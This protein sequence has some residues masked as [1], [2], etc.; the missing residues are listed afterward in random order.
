MVKAPEHFELNVMPPE[1][2]DTLRKLLCV[3]VCTSVCVCK[4]CLPV[5]HWD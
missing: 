3:C 4:L 2:M 1:I 5:T